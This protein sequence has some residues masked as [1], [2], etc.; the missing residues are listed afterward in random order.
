MRTASMLPV[1]DDVH[2]RAFKAADAEPLFAI[3]EANRNHLH[4][5]VPWVEKAT[6]LD[7]TRSYVENTRARHDE[8]RACALFIIEAGTIRGVVQLNPID[9]ENRIGEVGYWLV[10]EA[11]G[12]GLVVRSMRVLITHAFSTLELNRLSLRAAVQNDRS[13]ATAT[14]LGFHFEGILREVE[15]Y[16]EGYVSLAQYSMLKNESR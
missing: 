1:D 14:R 5:W 8:G 15:R 11:V 2:L 10:R 9:L 13:R 16:P 12:R 6:T 7:D 3:V 4:P